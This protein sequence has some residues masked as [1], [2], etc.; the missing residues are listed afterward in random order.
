MSISADA[1]VGKSFKYLAIFDKTLR[2]FVNSQRPEDGSITVD[3]LVDIMTPN[4]VDEIPT[5]ILSTQISENVLSETVNRAKERTVVILSVLSANYWS[6]LTT[7]ISEKK[8]WDAI[9]LLAEYLTRGD[10]TAK[11]IYPL[12]VEL[13]VQ[14]TILRTAEDS[15]DMRI[16]YDS[17]SY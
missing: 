12:L 10:R 2:K 1:Y 6:D 15:A 13:Y 5:N 16:Q 4:T 3:Y 17:M 7:Q 14:L 11:I 8:R 9:T